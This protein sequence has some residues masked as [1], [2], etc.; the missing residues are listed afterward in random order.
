MVP[1]RG[2]LI[3]L[4]NIIGFLLPRDAVAWWRGVVARRGVAAWRGGDAWWRG[5]VAWRGASSRHKNILVY[6]SI[7]VLL[8]YI[9]IIMYYM[10]TFN[11]AF[12][13]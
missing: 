4:R 6:Y 3:G 8:Y 1:W 10:S 7:A 11:I 9:L 5:G 2:V 13:F 12:S